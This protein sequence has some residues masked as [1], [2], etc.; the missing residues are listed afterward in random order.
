MRMIGV[1][2]SGLSSPLERQHRAPELLNFELLT[3][4]KLLFNDLIVFLLIIFVFYAIQINFLFPLLLQHLPQ[5]LHGQPHV[6]L[7]L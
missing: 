7:L 2:R 5:L 3:E 1:T 4:I 6:G